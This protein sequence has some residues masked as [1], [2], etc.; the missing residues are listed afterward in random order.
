[1][2]KVL[3][4][5]PI[6][7]MLAVAACTSAIEV[8]ASSSA[9][10]RAA[11]Y[12]SPN[13]PSITLLTMVNT[14]SGTGEH[15][16][17]LINGSQQVIYDPAGS[18][19]HSTA[20]RADDVN[21]GMHPGLV[22]VYKSF[23]ARFG[24]YVVAQEVPVSR[25]LA[26]AMLAKAIEVGTTSQL[27][28]ANSTSKVLNSF[29]MFRDIPTTFYPGKIMREFAKIPGVATTYTYEEDEGQNYSP[30]AVAQN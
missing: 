12:V 19:R 6:L 17:I 2:R 5:L 10:I 14:N 25:E 11:R 3:S 20:P 22:R 13:P 8:T 16:A 29:E 23:H 21:Y 18:F 1:M 27:F 4:L 24:Y 9:E 30:V 26:D 15:S 28:C 7:A